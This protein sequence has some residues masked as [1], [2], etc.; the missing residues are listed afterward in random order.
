MKHFVSIIQKKKK[1]EEAGVFMARFFMAK[2]VEM[3]LS[4]YVLCRS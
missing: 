1:K 3:L 4:K 2:L